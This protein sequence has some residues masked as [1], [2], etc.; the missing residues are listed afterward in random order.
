VGALGVDFA[1]TS[2]AQSQE[3]GAEQCLDPQVCPIPYVRLAK[4]ETVPFLFLGKT[5]DEDH[6]RYGDYRRALRR[7]P[8]VRSCLIEREREKPQ[9]DLR[10]IDWDA[11]QDIQ[12]IEVCIY[13]IVTSIGDIEI[14]KLWLRYHGFTVGQLTRI[15]SGGYVPEYR[16]QPIFQL[17][18]RLESFRKIVPRGLLTRILGLELG[19]SYSID[20]MFS[21][22]I[23]LVGVYSRINSTL[24]K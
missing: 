19:L 10:R 23:Q 11:I 22:D 13:R 12:E 7:F 16:T 17:W 2:R 15:Y 3:P 24:D 14:A 8:D 21:Q 9:P 20:M 5:V 1:S 6:P 18:S 4:Q